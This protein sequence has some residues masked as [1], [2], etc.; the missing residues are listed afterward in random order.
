MSCVR[1]R[2]SSQVKAVFASGT[3]CH[4]AAVSEDGGLYVWGRNE[5]GQCGSGDLKNVYAPTR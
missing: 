1:D 2:V 4:Y 5:R 3:A